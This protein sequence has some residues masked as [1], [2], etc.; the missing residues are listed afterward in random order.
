MLQS[1]VDYN[2][3]TESDRNQSTGNVTKMQNRDK[4]Q[5]I[6]VFSLNHYSM[7]KTN[8]QDK[9]QS[10]RN[11]AGGLQVTEGWMHY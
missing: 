5:K 4:A 1:I 2:G 11:V 3:S 6:L 10:G 8:L 9:Q 7:K